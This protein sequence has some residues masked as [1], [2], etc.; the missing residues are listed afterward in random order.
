[1]FRRVSAMTVCLE[2]RMTAFDEIRDN[3]ENSR[4]GFGTGIAFEDFGYVRAAVPTC[5]C[6]LKEMATQGPKF[7]DYFYGSRRWFINRN[8]PTA[9]VGVMEAHQITTG[10]PNG[11]QTILRYLSAMRLYL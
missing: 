4:S 2:P 11:A 8:L 10:D 1:M 5:W 9:A 7:Y 3:G 6:M